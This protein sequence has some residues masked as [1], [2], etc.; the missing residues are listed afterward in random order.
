MSISI[1]RGAGGIF[2]YLKF[3]KYKI[4]TEWEVGGTSHTPKVIVKKS[5]AR[6]YKEKILMFI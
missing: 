5:K 4:G 2:G 3:K 6:S 1:G